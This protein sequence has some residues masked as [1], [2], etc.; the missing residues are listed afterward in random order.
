MLQ[1]T[2]FRQTRVY[3][4]AHEEGRE[5]GREAFIRSRSRHVRYQ[6]A[7]RRA[8]GFNGGRGHK[9]LA[10]SERMSPAMRPPCCRPSDPYGQATE[11]AT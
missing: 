10:E 9:I 8:D 11:V 2:D 5:K 1:I 3:Q 6:I 4:E 7:N